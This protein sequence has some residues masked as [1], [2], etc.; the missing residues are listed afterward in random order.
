MPPNILFILTDQQRADTLGVINPVIRTPILDKLCAEGTRFTQAYTPAPVCVAAR[1][2]LIYGQYPLRTGCFEN[3]FPMPADTR[4][5]PT[6]MTAL[7]DTGYETHGVGKMHF[8]PDGK[9]LMGF[10]QRDISEEMG[11]PKED[12][13]TAWL[14]EIGYGHVCEPKGAR[15]EMYYIPQPSPL[16]AHAHNSA[17]VAEKSIQY[18]QSRD[19]SKPFLLWS[20]FIDPHPPFSPPFP[21]NKLYRGPSMPLPK[22][23][24]QMENLWTYINHVQNRYKYRDQGIDDNLLR[25]I[26]AYYYASISFIDYQVGRILNEL[27]SQ[28]ELDNTLILWS[29]DHGEFLGDYNCFGKRSFLNSAAAIPL[30]MRLPGRFPAGLAVNSPASLVDIYPTFLSVAGCPPTSVIDGLDLANLARSP[31]SRE[32]VFGDYQSGQPG[33]ANQSIYM[34]ATRRWKYIYSASEHREFLFDLLVDPDETRNRSQTFGYERPLQE[35]RLVVMSRLQNHVYTHNLDGG[36]W[37]KLPPPDFP[38]DPDGG[39]IFQDPSWATDQMYLPGY[40]FEEF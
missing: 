14:R 35:M 23:P 37:R 9:A 19:R 2:A 3:G 38:T 34:A 7:S 31:E 17:W 24:P 25:V 33:D 28:E 8:T 16:P 39:F 5:N 32:I 12:D 15:G 29:S 21:W 13:Y 27:E 22:R 1:C 36:V 40:S 6:F 26:K 20:S 18:L 30:V 10:D 11:D 4:K